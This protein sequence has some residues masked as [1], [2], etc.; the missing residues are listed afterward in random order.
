MSLLDL[1]GG[2]SD[3]RYTHEILTFAIALMFLL[4]LL[5]NLF[6][7][8]TAEPVSYQEY[9][10]QLNDEYTNMTGSS[11]T[12]ESVWGLSGIYLPYTGGSYGYTADGWLHGGK[13]HDYTPSQYSNGPTS[14]I[15]SDRDT[16]GDEVVNYPVYRYTDVPDISTGLDVGDMYTS[17]S[18]DASQKSDIFFSPASKVETMQG[19]YY[20]YSGYRYAFSPLTDL[21]A[22]DSNGDQVKIVANT[23]SLSLIWYSYYGS[24]GIA[25][26][27]IISGSDSGVSY[28]TKNEVVQAFNSTTNASKFEMQFNGVTCNLYVRIDPYYTSGGMSVAECFDNGYWSIMVTSNSANVSSYTSTDY[29]LSI[30]NITETIIDLLTF[31]LEDYGFSPLVSTVASA[32]VVVPLYVG[33][34][35]MGLT[36]TPL[37]FGA[38]ALAIFQGLSFLG[39]WL[40]W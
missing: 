4:P 35:S 12:S 17:I 26:Q 29:E 31:N 6:A 10:D 2:G 8:P 37:L 27:L 20:E 5:I 34:I 16:S 25:G 30:F 7:V 23:S 19:F 15:V 40:P 22:F 18:M 32:V 24:E 9:I 1:G 36:F 14:Y 28:L 33:L 3:N 13:I 11:P 39:D 38:G 21:Y